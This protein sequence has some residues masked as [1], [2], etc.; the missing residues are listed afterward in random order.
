MIRM[1]GISKAFSGN[2]VLSNVE[3]ELH[4]GEIHAL[5]GENGAGKSTLMKILSGIYEKDAGSVVVDGQEMEFKSPKDSEG[6]G[7]A[8]IHQELNILPDLSVAE[9]LFLGKEKTYGL[10]GIMR[11][12]EMH[13]EAKEAADHRNCQG[14][15]ERCEIHH[16][17]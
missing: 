10:F 1:S 7:I 2:V 16:H 12:K 14:H 4:D 8:V 17:G 13:K 9:N 15:C 11:K 5:M 6:Q 3:F